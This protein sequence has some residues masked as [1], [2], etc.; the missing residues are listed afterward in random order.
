MTFFP[1]TFLNFG[2]ISTHFIKDFHLHAFKK[3]YEYYKSIKTALNE[4]SLYATTHPFSCLDHTFPVH[5]FYQLYMQETAN[6]NTTGL[7][8]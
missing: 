2:D 7:V 1:R 5:L 8:Q 6:L 4:A 3:R